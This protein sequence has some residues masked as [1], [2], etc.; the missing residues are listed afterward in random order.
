MPDQCPSCERVGC[1]GVHEL[2]DLE[3]D[4]VSVV[5]RGANPAAKIVLWKSEV[6]PLQREY[7][8][9]DQP[10]RDALIKAA[11]D[12]RKATGADNQPASAGTVTRRP[13]GE[14]HGYPSVEAAPGSRPENMLPLLPGQDT[15]GW[16]DRNLR[17]MAQ[18]RVDFNQARNLP[19]AIA[20]ITELH[21]GLYD[22]AVYG[23][24]KAHHQPP[25]DWQQD[26]DLYAV[27]MQGRNASDY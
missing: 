12:P 4:E 25:P 13:P 10:L 20:Q 1:S 24:A 8:R 21:P 7:Q 5:K 26:A 2:V 9:I 23:Y 17:T 11:T 19:E 3:V 18:R 6:G 22:L 27:A 15:M 14:A 16:V